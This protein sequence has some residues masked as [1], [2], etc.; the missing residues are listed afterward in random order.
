MFVPEISRWI[1]ERSP[2]QVESER[3][4]VIQALEKARGAMGDTGAG[5]D[6]FGAVDDKVSLSYL[7]SMSC[8]KFAYFSVVGSF[9][10]CWRKAL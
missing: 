3:H 5:M 1:S 7:R 9:H 4:S 8:G 6:W 10:G 2:A